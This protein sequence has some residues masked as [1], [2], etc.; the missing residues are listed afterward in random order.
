M[1]WNSLYIYIYFLIYI[2]NFLIYIHTHTDFDHILFFSGPFLSLYL[3]SML[4][5][6]FGVTQNTKA[7][8]PSCFVYRIG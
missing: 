2:L 1:I 4:A 5:L 7:D 8:K 3:V 6:L